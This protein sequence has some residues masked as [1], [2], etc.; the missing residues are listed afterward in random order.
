MHAEASRRNYFLPDTYRSMLR[1]I[2]PKLLFI[3]AVITLYFEYLL[4]DAAA[5]DAA[6]CA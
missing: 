1:A 3:H 6:E 4:I 2:L 5:I